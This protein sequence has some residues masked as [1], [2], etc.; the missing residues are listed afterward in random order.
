MIIYMTKIKK[1]NFKISHITNKGVGLVNEDQVIV[2]NNL[3]GVFDGATSLN[4]YV[5]NEGKT[6]GYLASLITKKIFE[7]NNKPLVDLTLEANV[8]IKEEMIVRGVDTKDKNNLWSTTAAAVKIGSNIF[9]WLRTSDSLIIVVYLN[10]SYR[11]IGKFEDHDLNTMIEWKKLAQKKTKN[12]FNKLLNVTQ[13]NRKNANIDYGVINGEKEIIN[14]IQSGQ[15]SLDNVSDI[16]LFTDG[17]FIPKENPEDKN[18]W[19]KFVDLYNRGGLKKIKEFVRTLEEG[20]IECWKY[21]RFKQ[22]DDISAV[23]INF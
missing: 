21:P 11:L 18:D 19:D 5:N 10:K 13:E 7:K 4:K 23:A 3:F 16:I 12:I 6:G 20:D 8:A 14:F 17:L 15:E 2:G 9:E 1:H 22:H